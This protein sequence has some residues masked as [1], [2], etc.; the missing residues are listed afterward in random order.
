MTVEELID[1]LSE[2]DHDTIVV[3][4][5]ASGT[6]ISLLDEVV[7][8]QYIEEESYGDFVSDEEIEEDENINVQGS[9]PAVCLL[10]ED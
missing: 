3:L 4:S 7:S 8:G 9:Q 2:Y 5:N 6:R 1:I 10:S